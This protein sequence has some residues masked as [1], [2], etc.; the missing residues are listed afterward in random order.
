[1]KKIP[2]FSYELIDE[3]DKAYPPIP[4]IDVRLYIVEGDINALL[5]RASQRELIDTLLA[6]KE[7]EQKDE[8]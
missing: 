3:L 1:M 2:T 5:Q 8:N 6:K 4:A 7:K